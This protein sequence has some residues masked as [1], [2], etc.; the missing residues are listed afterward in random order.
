MTDIVPAGVWSQ[1]RV[2][3]SLLLGLL[4]GILVGLLSSAAMVKWPPGAFVS[5]ADPWQVSAQFGSG[6]ANPWLKAHVAR[7]GLFALP[8]REAVYFV[9]E[10][11]SADQPLSG[12]CRYAISGPVPK[13]GWA[14]LTA[15]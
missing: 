14:S 11:D 8:S 12:D 2:G 3:K 13:G 5:R 1:Q 7:Y 6:Q 9:A 15:S 10:H 4:L